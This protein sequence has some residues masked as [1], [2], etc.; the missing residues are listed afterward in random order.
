MSCTLA[1]S[2]RIPDLEK[3]C[4]GSVLLDGRPLKCGSD[5]RAADASQV[6]LLGEAC[7]AFKSGK[8]VSAR[9]PCDAIIVY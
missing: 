1:L 4:L 7:A 5:W 6:E 2:G 9:F 3:A 8:A